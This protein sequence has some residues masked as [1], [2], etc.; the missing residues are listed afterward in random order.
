MPAPRTHP[1][2]R[3]VTGLGALIVLIGLLGGAPLA[4]L[5]LAG[6]P[7]PDHLP[8]LDQ[9]GTTLTSRDDG[10]LF[11]RALALVG[12]A[13]WATFALSVL[14][15]LPARILRR[16]AVRLPGLGR[17][18]RWAA[19]LVG[20]VALIVVTSPA[21][22]AA[23][24]AVAT[25]ASA[26]AAPS[27]GSAPGGPLGSAPGVPAGL[28]GTAAGP[29]PAW[30]AG[31][32]DL[33]EEGVPVYRVERGDY[34]GHIADRYLGEFNRYPEL[35]RLNEIRDPDRIRPGQLLHLPP[36]AKD[37]GFREHA[38]GLVA[39]P[40]PGHGETAQPGRPPAEQPGHA[41]QP[42][43]PPAGQP[44]AGQP[45]AGGTRQ[46]PEPAGPPAAPVPAQPAGDDDS[47]T[48]V[49]GSSRADTVGGLN[50]PLAVSA[51]IAVA[52]IVGAQI[53][54]VLG[55]RGRADRRAALGNGRHR[56]R[57]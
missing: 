21:A 56:L 6:N 48:Y 27:A 7:L 20:S 41:P 16:P 33:G 5:A 44:S 4:L 22:T 32:A 11:L 52:G 19:T 28:P 54:A 38:S 9:I 43:Q 24:A 18:Q 37:R 29:A 39:I 30:L 17:Q 23:S 57:H 12:W 49:L 26:P 40:P 53:G 1:A 35:A 3:F 2:G 25:V 31:A 50:R 15:E 10:Q 42:G 45:P 13:G 36:V 14:V 47:T 46:A 51:V 34:L 8:T 55:L